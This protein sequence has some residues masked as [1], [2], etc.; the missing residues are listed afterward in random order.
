MDLLRVSAKIFSSIYR[1]K[2]CYSKGIFIFY[3]QKWAKIVKKLKNFQKWF[4][5]IDFSKM[6]KKKYFFKNSQN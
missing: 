3:F 6:V 5:K 1:Q 4:K 2:L